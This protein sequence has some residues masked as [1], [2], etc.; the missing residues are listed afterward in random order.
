MNNYTKFLAY[1]A[2]VDK[3]IKDEDKVLVLLSSLPDNDYETFILT[4]INSKQSLSYN[5]VLDAVV[6]HELRW[7]DN[8]SSNSTSAEALTVKGRSFNQKG[9]GNRGR[10]KSMSDLKE[11]SVLSTKKDTEKLIVR[12]SRT[13][14]S[15]S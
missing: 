5:E 10:L 4:L 2:H 9:K 8:E 15:Q 12:S 7:K 6:N 14:K 1:L 11:N 3:L 13:R